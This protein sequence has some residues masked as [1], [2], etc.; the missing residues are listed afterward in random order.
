MSKHEHGYMPALRFDWLTP[1]YDPVI[2]WT[3]REALFKPRLVQQ[4]NIQPGH[5][6]LD[7]GCGT[8]TL[9]ILIKQTHPETHVVGLDGDPK[10]LA[11]AR[12]KV[13]KAGVT[14]TLDQGMAFELP[15]PNHMF[16]RVLT[17]LLLHHLTKDN[18]RRT[19]SEVF[20]VLRPGGELHVADFGKPH[21]AV[22]AAVS[23]IVRWLEEAGDNM[24]GLLPVLIREAGF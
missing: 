20:R 18:K 10:V 7:L 22:M 2:R 3:M 21:N 1:L 13:A 9:T 23:L 4:A 19:L 15:Y 6:V 16:D 11:L 5:R 12:A 8:A 14:V 17:S 24:K